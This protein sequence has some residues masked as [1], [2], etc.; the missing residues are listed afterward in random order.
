LELSLKRLGVE[1]VDTLMIHHLEGPDDLAELEVPGGGF[2]LMRKA[3][4]QGLCR[5]I[6]VSTHSDWKVLLEAHRRHKFDHVM[7]SLNVATGGYTDLGFEEN[8][9]PVLREQ[10]VGVTAMK[11]MGAGQIVNAHPAYDHKSCIRYT[12][13]L[14]GVHS[15]T[16][17]MPNMQYMSADVDVAAG[18][19]PYSDEEMKALKAK[20]EGEVKEAFLNFMRTHS[21]LA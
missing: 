12:L 3:K 7:I 5:W 17:T 20:A 4:E 19:E 13:S 1:Y 14:P 6:G 21:D 15:V 2:E 18:F 8:A 10:N 11:A 9:L 16:V